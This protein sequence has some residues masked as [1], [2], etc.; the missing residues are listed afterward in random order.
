MLSSVLKSK[1]AVHVNIEIIRA[2]VKLRQILASNTELARK[3]YSFESK[4]DKQVKIVF[5]AIHTI[6]WQHRDFLVKIFLCLPE[7]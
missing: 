4:Y 1:R 2:F 6:N 7:R 5:D 3:M